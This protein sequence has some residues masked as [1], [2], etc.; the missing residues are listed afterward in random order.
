MDKMNSKYF[1]DKLHSPYHSAYNNP[2][3]FSYFNENPYD[4][5][6]LPFLTSKEKGLMIKLV[7]E[8]SD[9]NMDIN[10]T[11]IADTLNRY[12]K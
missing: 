12:R 7:H 2:N 10:W 6:L 4:K 1:V 9:N 8:F 5:G 11:T 3:F